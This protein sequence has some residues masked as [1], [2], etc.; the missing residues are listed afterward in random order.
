MAGKNNALSRA[1][2]KARKDSE[3]TDTPYRLHLFQSS[4]ADMV[5]V[6]ALLPQWIVDR[7]LALVATI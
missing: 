2:P 1:V 6:D 7:L 4:A 3:E 5:L